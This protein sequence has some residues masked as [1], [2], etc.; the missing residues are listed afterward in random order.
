MWLDNVGKASITSQA[1]KQLQLNHLTEAET[2]CQTALQQT[3][4][5]QAN[6]GLTAELSA[7]SDNFGGLRKLVESQ[8]VIIGCYGECTGCNA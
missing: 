1:V 3:D 4:G 8:Q 2:M 6:A 7:L 5:L